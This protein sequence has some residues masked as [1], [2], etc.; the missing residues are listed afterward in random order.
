MNEIKDKLN[1]HI[2]MDVLSEKAKDYIFTIIEYITK[3]LTEIKLEE[4]KT[5]R[6]VLKHKYLNREI[7]SYLNIHQCYMARYNR[8]ILGYDYNTRDYT[9]ELTNGLLDYLKKFYNTNFD[10]FERINVKKL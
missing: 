3:N 2:D 9:V 4:D 6:F 8:P 1:V 7:E 5:S 10:E